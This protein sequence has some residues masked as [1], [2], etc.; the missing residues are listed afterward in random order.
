MEFMAY[1][2]DSLHLMGQNK[3]LGHRWYDGVRP[4]VYE[5]VDAAAV[6]EDVIKRAGLVVA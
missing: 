1:V 4:R 5:D 3:Y 2:T 6:V